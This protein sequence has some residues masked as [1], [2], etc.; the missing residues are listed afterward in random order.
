MM[1]LPPF[2]INKKN[3]KCPT[4]PADEQLTGSF[5]GVPTGC[6]ARPHAG[7]GHSAARP[8]LA[9]GHAPGPAEWRAELRASRCQPPGEQGPE[10]IGAASDG[11]SEAGAQAGRTVGL[12]CPSGVGCG[13]GSRS[14]SAVIRT[15][16]APRLSTVAGT[17]VC[18]PGPGS[19]RPPGFGQ[20]PLA[21]EAAA[22]WRDS[23]NRGHLAASS[24]GGVC[25]AV[26]RPRARRHSGT[27]NQFKNL[28][29]FP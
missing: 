1:T 4:N 5:L 25:P 15:D 27:G 14:L 20:R 7:E 16:A 11:F 24:L 12:S 29:P 9:V 22:R 23:V 10:L 2:V 8:R 26:G 19:C 17:R 13:R 18:G 3:D 6:Q 28:R 21:C